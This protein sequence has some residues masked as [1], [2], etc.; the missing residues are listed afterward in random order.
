MSIPDRA[1]NILPRLLATPELARGTLVLVGHSMGGLIIKEMLRL[2]ESQSPFDNRTSDFEERVRKTVFIGTPHLGSTF[3]TLAVKVGLLYRPS[4]A[5]RGLSKN[6]THLRTLNSW[7]R[8]YATQHKLSVLGLG[9]SQRTLWGRIVTVDS[10]DLGLPSPAKFFLLDDDHFSIVAP[11]DRSADVYVHLRDFVET[12][13]LGSHGRVTIVDG[14]AEIG[15]GVGDVTVGINKILDALPQ[16]VNFDK[17]TLQSGASNAVVTSELRNRTWAMRR[18]RFSDGYDLTAE[19]LRLRQDVMSGE[20]ATADRD[21]RRQGLAWC[22]RVLSARDVA[23]AQKA[24]QEANALGSGEE[25]VIALAF[26]SLH[27]DGNR[28]SALSQIAGL[29]SKMSRSASLIIAGHEL[30][31]AECIDWFSQTHWAFEDLDADGKFILEQKRLEAGQVEDCLADAE[32]VTEDD[33]EDCPLLLATV[34]AVNLAKALPEEFRSAVFS[35]QRFEIDDIIL[36]GDA[37]SMAHRRRAQRKYEQAEVAFRTIGSLR[38]ANIVSD[39]ALWLA[40]LDPARRAIAKAQLEAS[41]K[42][43]RHSLRRLPIALQFGLDIDPV[44]AEREIEAASAISGGTSVEAAIGRFAIARTKKPDDLAAYLSTHRIQLEEY[45]T[46][47]FLTAV[48]IQALARAGK[49]DAASKKLTILRSVGAPSSAVTALQRFI[50]EAKGADPVESREAQFRETDTLPALMSLIEILK[51][52]EDWTRLVPFAEALV[53]RAPTIPNTLLLAQALYQVSHFE[54][55]DGLAQQYPEFIESSSDLAGI[56][57]W[58]YYRLGRL[59]EAKTTALSLEKSLPTVRALLTNIAIASG[60]W[61]AVSAMIEDDWVSR[62]SRSAE[63]LLRA[64]QLAHHVGSPRA[65]E[66]VEQAALAAQDDPA[67]LIACYTEAS[68]A[69]WEETQPV[70]DWLR[71]AIELSGEDGPVQRFDIQDL[72]DMQPDWNEKE[73]KV[74]EA[75]SSGSVPLFG[76]ANALNQTLLQI[77]LLPPLFNLTQP[78]IR[79]RSIVPAFS[80]A[81]SKS[82]VNRGTAAFDPTALLLLSMLGHLAEALD[83]FDEVI[84]PHTTLGWLLAE[85]RKVGTGQPSRVRAAVDL[86]K[87]VDAGHLK[88]FLGVSNPTGNLE[89]EVGSDLALFLTAAASASSTATQ[90]VVVRPFPVHRP[91]SLMRE[92]VDLSTYS[93]VLAGSWEVVSALKALGHLTSSEEEKALEYLSQHEPRWPNP[94]QI[95]RGAVLYIDSLAANYLQHLG[96]LDRLR[97]AGFT[98]IVSE[99]DIEQADLLIRQASFVDSTR[100]VIEDVRSNLAQRIQSGRVRL[101]IAR[102]QENDDALS[103]ENH[104]SNSLLEIAKQV[105]VVVIDDRFFNQHNWME[106]EGRKPINT[107]LEVLTALHNAGHLT[108]AS[109]NDARAKMRRAGFAMVPITPEELLEL[110]EGAPASDGTLS[111]TAELKAIRESLLQFRMS[112]VLQLPREHPWF[113][114]LN[115]ALVGALRAQWKEGVDFK[116]A[117]AKSNWVLG[118]FDIRRWA[119]RMQPD[120]LSSS[121]RYQ[122]QLQLLMML[123]DVG[124]EVRAK[125]WN[126]VTDVVLRPIRD[127]DPVLFHNLLDGIASRIDAALSQTENTEEDA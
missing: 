121:E 8:N 110:L 12:A 9:E 92:T 60:D 18:A 34:A 95:A 112:D 99:S 115:L 46:T 36:A 73:R 65:R 79:R 2:V 109:L 10:A 54:E 111:E 48:E 32:L 106:S 26:I 127:R 23:A 44:A 102:R 119:H 107:S 77:F 116:N 11:K 81:R 117:I 1:S 4:P 83:Y 30:T 58:G 97:F 100:D 94:T 113:D 27:Q 80:G 41:M 56:I 123:P 69:G 21:V 29:N 86:R 104:P 87:M 45:Y 16:L 124:D 42:D 126:W 61:N 88:S 122:A 17:A 28:S 118:L 53:R 90:H 38:M 68:S 39:Y 40:L 6:D 78:D 101:G 13:V 37:S 84:V 43:Q 89:Q 70:G 114:E 47:E 62:E 66:L 93:G 14:L 3:S 85:N 59:T 33:F 31:P 55:L 24:L 67:I 120:H 49:A 20:L 103:F 15:A 96:L 19:A 22:A 63:E 57:A 25:N 72:L 50:D 35:H 98:A 64:G 82:A 91:R 75:V 71:T 51:E 74:W 5:T 125:Y 105:D 108:K 7:F 52:R 76:A